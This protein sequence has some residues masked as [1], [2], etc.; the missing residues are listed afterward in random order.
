MAR[1]FISMSG[2]GR[3]HATRVRAVTE[4]LRQEH[5]ICLFAPGDAHELLAPGYAGS[6]VRVEQIPGL[7]FHYRG[8]RV[9][10]VR[11]GREALRYLLTLPRLIRHL[12]TRIRTER[13]DLVI[14][15]FEPALPRAAKRTGT[16][17]VSLDHQH[18]LLTYDLSG[19]PRHLRRHAA[20]MAAVV[21]LYCS[22]QSETIVS[23]FYFPPLR[24]EAHHVTQ[25]GVLLRPEVV[26]VEPRP[27]DHLVSY[28][29]KFA[30]ENVLQALRE[31]GREVRVYGLG[32]R[33]SEGNLRF[34]PISADRFLSDLAGSAALVCTAGNQLVGE[35][36]YLGKPVL[37]A[38]EPG[39]YEQYM[40]AHFLG[41]SGAGDWAEMAALTGD[42][43]RG[44]LGNLELHRQRI[45]RDRMDGLPEALRLLRRQ[46]TT[47]HAPLPNPGL[48]LA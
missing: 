43:L 26:A 14:T 44:F 23:S 30:P 3:G 32:E 33:P 13:P 48:Q 18:F 31:C 17:L 29:R 28:W 21:R 37:A 41:L 36:L 47:H 22:G 7:R 1:I 38:P 9:D 35:A 16:R 40:N 4:G 34:R 6:D 12:E 8:R 2:E 45:Q 10:Y 46:L 24:P 39:N 27:G 15:D 19:L 11:T 25:V 42:R 5:E 20:Y